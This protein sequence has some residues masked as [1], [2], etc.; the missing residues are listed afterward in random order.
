MGRR[1]PGT[2]PVLPGY[3]HV[4]ALGTGGFADVFLY[5][6]AMPRRTIAVKVLLT[7]TVQGDLRTA[8]LQ[9]TNTLAHLATHPHVLTMY[10]AGI[11]SDGR[12]YLVTEFC[13]RGFGERFR[14]ETISA[15]EVIATG[16]AV[17]SALETAHRAGVL[18]RDIKP[19]NVLI[20]TFDRPVL[21]DFGI[22]ATLEH[23]E[24]EDAAQ[25]GLSVPWAPPEL[26]DGQSTGTVLSEIYSFGATL[27]ALLTGRSPY[28]KEEGPNDRRALASRIL[29]R[30]GP[31]P[32]QRPD[33]PPALV[34][35]I[36]QCLAKNPAKRPQS[37][38]EVLHRLQLA[39]SQLGL[40][41]STLQLAQEAPLPVPSAQDDVAVGHAG[42]VTGRLARLNTGN[43]PSDT[44]GR[45]RRRTAATAVAQFD[46]ATQLRS[47]GF[48]P[49]RRQAKRW[50]WV[51]AAAA[52]VLVAA[53]AV[54]AWWKPWDVAPGQIATIDAAAEPG[55]VV[56]S[57]A[58]PAGAADAYEVRVE[59]RPSV[60]QPQTSYR[61][62]TTKAGARVCVTVAVVRDGTVGAPSSPR[63]ARSGEAG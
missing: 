40:R 28:E 62:E 48:T 32:I 17:G 16:L 14:R 15:R 41:P 8:F 56:F 37:M 1:L 22:A 5:E 30:G 18:H 23:L 21:A 44:T 26:L 58:A 43:V 38:L 35:V 7:N 42:T 36:V 27:Y 54:L 24:A 11:A 3:T 59:G 61:V 46:D 9:E 2:P 63:C 52:A 55:A 13:P 31:A 25:V 12:P 19:A 39:E 53:A 4:R 33:A 49:L 45:R 50:Q 51:T 29:G 47:G 57:W 60:Q 20:T 34:D 10:E 6:Q